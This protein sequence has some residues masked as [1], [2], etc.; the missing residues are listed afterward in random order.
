MEIIVWVF[1]LYAAISISEALYL[2]PLPLARSQRETTFFSGNDVSGIPF[3]R[4]RLVFCLS[5][6]QI[7]TH[8]YTHTNTHTDTAKFLMIWVVTVRML[9]FHQCGFV[10]ACECLSC[11]HWC[12]WGWGISC[13]CTTEYVLIPAISRLQ[14]ISKGRIYVWLT[15]DFLLSYWYRFFISVIS[16]IVT[17]WNRWLIRHITLHAVLPQRWGAT[18]LVGWFLM[19]SCCP[20][21]KGGRA[22]VKVKGYFTCF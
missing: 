21:I 8:K 16:V 20:L 13:V 19:C 1:L 6:T 18:N 17:Y 10:L 11:Q 3:A 7:H 4:V 15:N 5:H 9:F 22:K 12:C 2:L 14:N